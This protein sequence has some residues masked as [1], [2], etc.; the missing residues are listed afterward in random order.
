MPSITRR[1]FLVGAAAAGAAVAGGGFAQ[2]A[3]G[4]SRVGL[5]REEHRVVVIGSGFG[6]GI[7]ALRLA[8]AGVPVVLLERGKRWSTGPNADTFPNAVNPDKRILWYQSAPQLFGKPAVFDPYVGLVEAVAGENMTTM[9]AAGLGGGSLVYQGMSLQPSEAV[10][11]TH[12]PQALDWDLMNRVHY[13][14]VARMLQLDTAP[15]ELVDSPNYLA[16]RIFARNVRRAGMPLSKIPMPIDWSF[17]LRELAGEMKPSYTNGSGAMG[18]NNGGKHTVDVT[19]I[20]AAEAT[21]NV[22]VRTLHQVTD[23]ERD[24]DGRWVV[25]VD[26]IDTTGAVLEN[27]ILTTDTLIM[28]AGSMNT[29]KL[30]VRAKATGRI[31]DLPDALGEGWG[32]NADRIYVW[33]NLED[34]FGVE[35]GGP[36]VY[37]SLNW[38]D[39]K[40]AHTVI[41]AS[42]PPMPIDA[43]S[44]MLVGYG[45][46]ES[47][48]RFVYDA[49]Q[50]QAV[51]RWPKDGDAR[52]QN[53]HIGP[54]VQRI[55]GPR[56]ILTD[57]NN[58]LNSTWHPL[59]G[60]CMGT[61][62]DLE[63]RVQ[64][65]RGL[66]V[67]DGALMPGNAAACN[68]S[69]SIAAVAE[70]AMDQIVAKDVG[71][72]I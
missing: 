47:R 26:R 58:V 25:Y 33:T 8:Q 35:Q 38:D 11:N 67:L 18:V 71:T 49:A 45:V 41:Q 36:V 15:D 13:P 16:P 17:A 66:Y 69:L 70:R 44:T 7:A 55:A 48:G 4:A 59:G 21:G 43:R 64:G 61:V 31:P 34:S 10:F 50:G 23:V 1:S 62:C 20:A 54:A 52:I 28:S 57:T 65:Q 27:K 40:S 37:G 29:T 60:A 14:R 2:A 24:K 3:P 51:L 56:S 19:Y 63:G 42:M 9:C 30:L 12:F 53:G 22:D 5:T 46:S 72:L 6:G 39:P 68:P 32:S